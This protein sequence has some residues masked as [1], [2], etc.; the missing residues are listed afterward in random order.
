MCERACLFADHRRRRLCRVAGS[1]RVDADLVELRVGRVFTQCL[2]PFGQAMPW[3]AHEGRHCLDGR[4]GCILR[5]RGRVGR[6]DESIEETR[7]AI[8]AHGVDERRMRDVP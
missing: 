2:G 5:E 7:V 4:L 8:A 6:F 1:L 3:T